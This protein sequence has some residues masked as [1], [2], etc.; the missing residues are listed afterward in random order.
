[1]WSVLYY[2]YKRT[3]E[4]MPWVS[5]LYLSQLVHPELLALEA[6]YLPVWEQLRVWTIWK[7]ACN[8]KNLNLFLRSLQYIP[9]LSRC[10]NT[11]RLEKS[12]RDLGQLKPEEVKE[13]EE[14]IEH[15]KHIICKTG[16]IT[17][18]T[19]LHNKD[20]KMDGFYWKTIKQLLQSLLPLYYSNIFY[21]CYNTTLLSLCFEHQI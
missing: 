15:N 16:Y 7:W 11:Y 17:N 3:G 4:L 21:L 9:K 14:Y 6:R 12:L 5:I 20:S 8:F 10:A 2:A 19:R 1:M 18:R 13:K